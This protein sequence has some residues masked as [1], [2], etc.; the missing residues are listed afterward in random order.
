MRINSPLGQVLLVGFVCF[1]CPG[2]FNVI[3]GMG[4]GGQMD[5]NTAKNGNVALYS[6]FAVFGCL[7]GGF[8]NILGGRLCLCLG[9]Q[10]AAFVIIASAI[11]GVGAGILWTAQGVVMMSYP[12][13]DQKGRCVAPTGSTP[14]Q[15]GAVNGVLFN[16]RTRSLNN[17]LY[18][19]SQMLGAYGLGAFLDNPRFGRRARAVYGL[20][21]VGAIFSA[22]WAGGLALQL[23]Y[24]REDHPSNIDFIDHPSEFWPKFILYIF[25]GMCDAMLQTY[26]YWVMG[27]LSNDSSVL[28]R[29]AGY[30]KG[31]QSAGAAIA[32]RIDAVGTAFLTQ[33]IINWGLFTLSLPFT[34]FV[35]REVK[36]T[37]NDGA[38]EKGEVA[39]KE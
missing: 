37:C 9:D 20:A 11:L 16:L 5:D 6:C 18:W 35:A 32:W 1:A 12:A 2:M 3:N 22:T 36:E 39:D 15:F 14:Y 21:I 33:L 29:Y 26:A 7:G 10:E 31:I 24:T 27:A 34:Y 4:A 38:E 8:Y 17:A 30:Y 13:E 23:Q 28:A 25:Y 19:G